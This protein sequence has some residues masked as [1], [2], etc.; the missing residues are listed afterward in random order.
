MSPAVP[1]P[2]RHQPGPVRHYGL[3]MRL[4]CTTMVYT[5]TDIQWS[6]RRVGSGDMCTG[7]ILALS[8]NLVIHLWTL[9]DI[10]LV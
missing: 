3:L 8:F 2:S 5:D 6:S 10:V 7:Q 1:S 4:L 9:R